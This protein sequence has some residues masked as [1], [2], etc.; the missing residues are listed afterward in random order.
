MGAMFGWR[1]RA[2][3]F[4]SRWNRITSS[5]S[6]TSR[7]LIATQRVSFWSHAFQ[8]APMPPLPICL[9]RM[10]EPSW[11]AGSF[12]YWLA[13]SGMS[14]RRDLVDE[15]LFLS[16]PPDVLEPGLDVEE[17]DFGS[18]C[19]MVSP[20]PGVGLGVDPVG[21]AEGGPLLTSRLPFSLGS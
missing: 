21:G 8:T 10:Y 15:G 20:P 7:N 12:R 1:R 18:S 3:S 2:A 5:S 4:A 14:S 17:P 11:R 9:T 16:V 6:E 13:S 19:L